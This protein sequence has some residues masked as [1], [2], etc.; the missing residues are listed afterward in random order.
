M[1]ATLSCP[2]CSQPIASNAYLCEFCGVDLAI[3]AVLAESSVG[4]NPGGSNGFTLTPEILV[5][6]LGD[7]L[8]DHGFLSAEQL[9]DALNYQKA[10]EFK[11]QPLLLGQALIELNLIDR[12]MLDKAVTEQILELQE[13]LKKSNKH[14]EQRV[15][16]RTADLQTALDKLTELNQLKTNFVSN[17]SHELRT[18][19]AHMIG[20]LDLLTTKA[21]GPLSNQQEDALNVLNKSYYRL[22]SL[23]DSLLMF[24]LASQGKMNLLPVSF[25]LKTTALA[26]ISQLQSKATEHN[27]S[28]DVNFPSDL[29][30]VKADKEKI[31][32]VL[33]QLIDNAIKFN[34]PGGNVE[35]K[36]LP[37]THEVSIIVSDS[38][39]GIEEHKLEEIFDA[40]HQLDG[41]P[42]RKYGGTGLGLSLAQRI[43]DAHGSKRDVTSEL[44]Q[45]ASFKFS[46]PIAKVD[47]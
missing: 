27:I 47:A 30:K 10:L 29:P 33:S 46:L 18:P 11:G 23:I 9:Q 17:I 41:S 1:T 32:W 28:L 3:A 16:E 45:G 25:S 5:P 24:S 15:K 13:A 44:D 19:L 36:A 14:L 34:L 6:R 4:L 31:A 7:Y 39:I 12:E 38:G 40:F 26:V 20:Y 2:N 42:S 22:Q 37:N 35:L 43:V 21:L 8:V